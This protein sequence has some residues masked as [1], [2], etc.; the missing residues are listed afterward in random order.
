MASSY[1]KVDKNEI[2]KMVGGILGGEESSELCIKRSHAKFLNIDNCAKRFR[3]IF[4]LLARTRVFNKFQTERDI[5]I[6]YID[7]LNRDL[8]QYFQSVEPGVQQLI[9]IHPLVPKELE[10]TKATF[11]EYYIKSKKAP[12]IHTIINTCGNLVPY[13]LSLKTKNELKDKFLTKSSMLTFEPVVDLKVNFKLIYISDLLDKTEKDFIL[14]TLHKIYTISVDMY[15]EFSKIDIDTDQFV[16]AVTMTVEKLRKQIPRCDEAFKKILD[17]T[18]LLKENYDGYYKDYVGSQ[19]SMIIAENFIQDVA[20]T[21]NKSPKLAFQFR[22]IIQHLR[23]VTNKLT[24][25]NPQYKDTF[26]SLLDQADNSYD[27]I[28]KS[29]AA[30]DED[31][32]DEEEDDDDDGDGIKEAI[33]EMTKTLLEEQTPE[34]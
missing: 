23:D 3:D 33:E 20:G 15:E 7:L 27:E 14:F 22:K 18:E 30:D 32:D 1:L 8:E 6:N 19:N 13:K 10:K 25:Q 12:I 34:I 21:V 29:I 28:K 26:S 4:V 16:K 2:K 11:L 17:S 31:A 24:A 5:I 9:D